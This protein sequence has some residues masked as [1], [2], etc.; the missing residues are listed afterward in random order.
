MPG[1][2][3]TLIRLRRLT[4]W[5]ADEHGIRADAEH[6]QDGAG[7]WQ[8]WLR[9][10]DGPVEL[11]GIGTK[12]EEL[13]V[14]IRRLMSA[15]VITGRALA[16][17]AAR[18]ALRGDPPAYRDPARLADAI[19]AE[20]RRTDFP[21]RPA[22]D[23]EEALAAELTEQAGDI[24]DPAAVAAL[25]IERPAAR[26]APGPAP[27]AVQA[28]SPAPGNG[29]ALVRADGPVAKDPLAGIME[30]L[31]RL[32]SMARGGGLDAAAALGSLSAARRVAAELERSELVFIEA[33]RDSGAT[34]A[35]IAA[36]MGAVGRQTAQ[37]RHT[38]LTRRFQRPLSVDM[39]P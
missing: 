14:D 5:L 26:K 21:E 36:A 22:G 1:E 38:D 31:A 13:G 11:P 10:Y 37:K 28:L 29:T 27:D 7:R 6:V 23:A 25:I 30:I 16:V 8:W 17:I 9:W 34:W 35:Q 24:T 39:P 2:P 32:I 20:A 12:A 4:A 15:R 19:V 3:K 33:A 18:T